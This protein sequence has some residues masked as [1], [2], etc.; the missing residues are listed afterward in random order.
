MAVL[1]KFPVKKTY[2]REVSPTRYID[3]NSQYLNEN[4][5]E[6]MTFPALSN[7]PKE[8]LRDP[9]EVLP[10]D[11]SPVDWSIASETGGND[12]STDERNQRALVRDYLAQKYAKAADT[13]GVDE[14]MAKQK[15]EN[16]WADAG[17]NVD[18]ML[19]AH[20]AAR[21]GPGADAAY[22]QGQK[23]E[24]AGAVDQQEALRQAKIKDYLT[25][26]KLGSEGVDEMQ[27][28]H[29]YDITN[30]QNDPTSNISRSYQNAFGSMFP[31]EAK[32][33]GG[34]IPN[35]SATEIAGIAK[36]Y[37][38]KAE[39]DLRQRVEMAKLGYADAGLQLQGRKIGMEEAKAGRETTELAPKTKA[40][41]DNIKAQIALTQARTKAVQAGKPGAAPGV[42]GNP[43]AKPTKAYEAVDRDYAKDY[44]DWTVSG[45]S[46]YDKN[47]KILEQALI[48]MNAAKTAGQGG[49]VSG[50][51]E[52][53]KYKVLGEPGRSP[54]G[55]MIQKKVENAV[56]GTLKA[57]AGANP[58]EGERAAVLGTAFNINLPLEQNIENVKSI[59]ADLNTRAVRNEE[60]ARYFEKNGTLSG[61]QTKEDSRMVKIQAPDGSI[62]PVPESKKDYYISKGGKV[63][64]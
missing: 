57:V 50:R 31:E 1:D 41:I 39:S 64:Q 22:W 9:N 60:K 11:K 12:I 23:K 36:M 56:I 20:S 61:Y 4:V 25:K 10:T 13:K 40:E 16:E 30:A 6:G 32:N 47:M 45:R 42:P 19:M 29:G 51:W 34:D 14:A 44:N 3:P 59:I 52:G 35:M 17:H 27:Q 48:E 55:L 8:Y 26:Q 49:D 33:M 37:G 21:G 46:D 5:P 53:G 24:A 18:R 58:T 7:V 38:A 54:K 62:R 15:Y 28:M 43:G 63:V 2:S